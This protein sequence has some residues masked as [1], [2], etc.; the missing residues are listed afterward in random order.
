[1][2]EHRASVVVPRPIEEVFDFAVDQV[3]S[4]RWQWQ[5]FVKQLSG[6]ANTAGATYERIRMIA[7]DRYVHTYELAVVAQPARFELRSTGGEP[8]FVYDYTFVVEGEG[9]RIFLDVDSEGDTV[10]ETQN[11]LVFLKRVLTGDA[12]LGE[13]PRYPDPC[14]RS[15]ESPTAFKTG[16]VWTAGT[17]GAFSL[18]SIGGA[19]GA[20]VFFYLWFIAVFVAMTAL[21]V[22]IALAVS[23]SPNKAKGVFVGVGTSILGAVL[24]FYV[25]YIT[26]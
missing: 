1:M 11:R 5:V 6:E 16:F 7:G 12:P 23:G 2:A 26:Y 14:G 20:W 10:A 13:V 19:G 4:S 3:G 17:I 22:G 8:S 9:T 21:V 24:T 25:G 18:L 15:P